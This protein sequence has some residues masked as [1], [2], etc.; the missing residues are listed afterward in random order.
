MGR[1]DVYRNEGTQSGK[2]FPYFLAVQSELLENLSTT[3]VV[4]LGKPSMV[5]GRATQ[6]LTPLLDVNGESLLMYTPELAAVHAS[7]LRK[8]IG[9]LEPQRA[10]ILRALDFLFNGI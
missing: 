8:R 1:F 4:P 3:V 5:S 9:N 10:T 2:R 6:T 7:G